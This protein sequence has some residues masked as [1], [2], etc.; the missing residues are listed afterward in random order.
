VWVD[1]AE[2]VYG[3]PR[4]LYQ[5]RAVDKRVLAALYPGKAKEIDKASAPDYRFYGQHSIAN[6]ALV[7]EG[8]HLPSSPDAKDGWHDIAVDTGTLYSERYRHETF[9][10]GVVRWNEESLGWWGTGLAQQLTGIQYEINML[11]RQAQIG[12]Y[13]SGNM[14]V[15]VERGSKI[16]NAQI[17]N[18]MWLTKLEYTG[19]PPIF[20]TPEPLS[21]TLKE[22]LQ[23][24]VDQA[25]AIT[26]IS[27]LAARGEIPAG[28]SGS[29]RA[30]L[31]YKDSDSQ[32]FV[33][34]TRQ[35]EHMHVDLGERALEAAADIYEECGEYSIPYATRR[36]V[37]NL[38]FEDIE[39]DKDE[40]VVQADISSALP[41]TL[42]GRTALAD[43]WK[44]S[45]YI[46]N[47]QAKK[48]SG[49]P[50]VDAELSMSLA[51]IE[52]IDERIDR[53]LSKGEVLS[54][55]PRMDLQL[56]FD[57][58]TLAFQRAELDGAP[59]D[60]L[61]LLGDF[62]DACHDQLEDAEVQEIKDQSAI[63]ATMSGGG[64]T[65]APTE[66]MPTEAAAWAR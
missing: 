11:V 41:Y 39:G 54:P 49:V 13:S 6:Q 22:M 40:F 23:F 61:D 30:Q 25:Y 29:G 35:Y 20:M 58:A 44:M 60:R 51:P 47:W 4:S 37:E 32:R 8:W 12:L 19:Q 57:R 53:I 5:V 3:E 65:A 16:V 10:F 46:D 59:P 31:V 56:A 33:Q 50:D 38:G 42:A 27:Q 43:Q 21:G 1:D 45:G 24:Y 26:G 17:N 63:Q 14:K 62:I 34:V 18:D 48:L 36:K 28:L 7:Y 55:H 66:P 2:A 64:P 15:A 52:L 9:P